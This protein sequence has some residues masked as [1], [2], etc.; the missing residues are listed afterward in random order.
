MGSIWSMQCELHTIKRLEGGWK[1]S[2]KYGILHALIMMLPDHQ[3]LVDVVVL[4][5]RDAFS[6]DKPLTTSAEGI[7]FFVC[8]VT[9]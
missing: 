4:P 8:D 2:V 6:L 9:G 1:A 7:L 3:N 5:C